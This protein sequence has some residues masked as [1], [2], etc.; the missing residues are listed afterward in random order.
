MTS[1]VALRFLQRRRDGT[2]SLDALRHRGKPHGER[3][4]HARLALH[5]DIASHRAAETPADGEAEAGATV[6]PGGGG[7]GLG[8]LLEKLR[9]LLAGHADA[10]VGDREP[11][12]PEA[13]ALL[14]RHLDGNQAP[15]GKLAGVTQE[16]E[17]RLSGARRIGADAPDVFGAVHREAVA[18]LLGQGP[19]GRHHVFDEGRDR[20]V[21]DV[22]LHAARFDLG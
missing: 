11:D 20:D 6:L 18:V 8:E 5:R 3:G 15:L 10:G 17:K 14:A 1:T 7:V 9:H 4:S 2:L 13:S 19:D 21:L 16:I 12:P 22:Q